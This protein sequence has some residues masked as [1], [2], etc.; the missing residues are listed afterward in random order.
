MILGAVDEL[1]VPGVDFIL[2]SDLA[3]GKESVSPVLSDKSV[4][5]MDT[6]QLEKGD[7]VI[8]SLHN[9]ESYDC[10]GGNT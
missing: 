6:R 10:T 8:F 5:S 3:D 1:P 2:G 7:Q 4:H 9:H